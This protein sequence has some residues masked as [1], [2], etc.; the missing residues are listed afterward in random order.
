M[1]SR[2]VKLTHLKHNWEQTAAWNSKKNL[3][4]KRTYVNVYESEKK[5]NKIEFWKKISNYYKNS[6]TKHS[7]KVLSFL[8]LPCPKHT[9]TNLSTH[10]QKYQNCH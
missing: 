4:I 5:L 8:I 3:K 1:K 10:F 6:G 9:G 2:K 7:V